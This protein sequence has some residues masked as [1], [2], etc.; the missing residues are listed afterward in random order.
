MVIELN[1]IEFIAVIFCS[2]A[3]F[4]NTP[5]IYFLI[6]RFISLT[7]FKCSILTYKN[8]SSF[9][10][11]DFCTKSPFLFYFGSRDKSWHVSFDCS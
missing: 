9:Y 10:L 2:M 8:G 5:S 3:I 1:L 11:S 6:L 7:T 4:V